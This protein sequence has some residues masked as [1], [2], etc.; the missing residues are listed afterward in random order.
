MKLTKIINQKF[1]LFYPCI[2]NADMQTKGNLNIQ[3]F[4]RTPALK[5]FLIIR[6]KNLFAQI[7]VKNINLKLLNILFDKSFYELFWLILKIVYQKQD[8]QKHYQ[9]LLLMRLQGEENS[10]DYLE[11]SLMFFVLFMKVVI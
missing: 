11:I 7:T 1:I 2:F 6:N 10:Y 4:F 8:S 9:Y 3:R 5:Q